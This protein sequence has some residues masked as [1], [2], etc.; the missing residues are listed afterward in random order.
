MLEK[1]RY[2]KNNETNIGT[3][4]ENFKKKDNRNINKQNFNIEF[5]DDMLNYNNNDNIKTSDIEQIEQKEYNNFYTNI[6]EKD[7]LEETMLN[8]HN[9][10]NNVFLYHPDESSSS[11]EKEKIEEILNSAVGKNEIKEENIPKKEHSSNNIYINVDEIRKEEK[12]KEEE[13][14]TVSTNTK[15]IVKEGKKKKKKKKNKIKTKPTFNIPNRKILKGY[16][17]YIVEEYIPVQVNKESKDIIYDEKPLFNIPINEIKNEKEINNKENNK[18]NNE[19]NVNN[20]KNNNFN[21]G[22][23]NSIPFHGINNDLFFNSYFSNNVNNMGLNGPFGLNNNYYLANQYN[24]NIVRFYELKIKIEKLIQIGVGALMNPKNHNH[25]LLQMNNDLNCINNSFNQYSTFNNNYNFNGFNN[26]ANPNPF[27]GNYFSNQH[28]QN[29][30]NYNHQKSNPE[31]YT[32][33]LKSKTD[34]PSIEK[35]SKIQVITSYVKDNS[36]VKQENNDTKIEKNVKN[37]INLDDIK[38]GKEKRTV[39][40]LNPIPPNYS[41]F[42]VSK[43][44]DKYLNIE[45]GKKQ[46]IYKALYVPLCKVI[47]KN[48]GYCFIMMVKPEYV[49]QFY[50]TFNGRIFG[51]KKC[52]KECNLF[53]AN[54]QGEDFLKNTED[55]P[56]RKPIIF[57][58]IKED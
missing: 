36:K 46:R 52:K 24:Q 15:T 21:F 20:V 22:N 9:D 6:S 1:E 47:G 23:Q 11:S 7:Y 49:I 43:L 32:I 41:S 42:D 5:G 28:A 3:Q 4:N 29:M 2:E 10:N 54:V 37:L 48:L 40:R 44:L 55:D 18:K 34:D 19:N 35:I 30:N 12:K 45:T 8:V 26:L 17:L 31:K 57:R 25:Y 27:F 33:T 51:K 53:W 56:I 39:V 16:S 58:D 14:T 13:S 38:S 50:N